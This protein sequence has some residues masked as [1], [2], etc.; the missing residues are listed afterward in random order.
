M[1]LLNIIKGRSYSRGAFLL[2]ILAI[3]I[4]V[5]S[6]IVSIFYNILAMLNITLIGPP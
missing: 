5:I 1:F 2:L 3:S 6:S 4:P